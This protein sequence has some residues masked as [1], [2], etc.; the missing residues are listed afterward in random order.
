MRSAAFFIIGAAMCGEPLSGLAQLHAQTRPPAKK[1][2][3]DTPKVGAVPKAVREAFQLDNYYTKY[4]NVSG[5]P[6]VASKTVDDRAVASAA[7]IVKNMLGE[8]P[9]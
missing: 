5:L 2:K 9:D 6:V 3:S 7:L 1:G 8:R 4:A